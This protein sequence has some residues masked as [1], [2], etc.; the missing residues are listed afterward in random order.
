MFGPHLLTTRILKL[1]LLQEDLPDVWTSPSH[2]K[3][4]KAFPTL[5]KTCLIFGPHLHT[6]FTFFREGLPDVWT[7]P[8]HS[9]DTQA[10]PSSE[11]TCLS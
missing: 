9:K 7:S 1:F 10:F 3:E 8:S 4:T 11:E 2:N 6:S 5:E